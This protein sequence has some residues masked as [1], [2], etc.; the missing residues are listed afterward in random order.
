MLLRDR[1]QHVESCVVFLA[2]QLP[3]HGN[4]H[5]VIRRR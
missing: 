1:I 5:K 3:R 4:P 2:Q